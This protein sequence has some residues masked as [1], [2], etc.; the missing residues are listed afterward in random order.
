MLLLYC[1]NG[2]CFVVFWGFFK[3]GFFSVVLEAVLDLAL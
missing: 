2:F 3:T 1:E